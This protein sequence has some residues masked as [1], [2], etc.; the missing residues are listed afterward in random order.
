[1]IKI[2][3]Q[4]LI[5]GDSFD[6][7][8]EMDKESFDLIL[9]DPPYNIARENNFTTMGRAGI[10]FGEW[11]KGFDLL[12]WI[13][14]AIPLLKKGGSMVIFNDWKNLGGVA[15]YAEGKGLE[16][17]D[18]IRWEKSNPMPRNIER[19][20][21]T[22]FEMMVWLVKSGGKWTFNKGD[23]HKYRRP[24]IHSSLTPKSEKIGKGHITQKPISIISELLEIHSNKGDRVLDPFVG[25]G[26]LLVSCERMGRFG[27]GIEKEPDYFEMSQG[28]MKNELL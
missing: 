1:M 24:E 14:S 17:K 11:D 25:S 15:R 26:T 13:D 8:K 16:I 6:I 2:G 3:N 21:V 7:L 12:T 18:L 23:G 22:D 5:L 19:R 27:V 28:R 9:T 4:S 20:Y 10:D